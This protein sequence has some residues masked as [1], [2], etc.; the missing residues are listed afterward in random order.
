VFFRFS[1][2]P[3]SLFSRKVE[4]FW[5][6]TPGPGPPLCPS[7]TCTVAHPG[8]PVFSVSPRHYV[9]V[10]PGSLPTLLYSNP[11]ICRPNQIQILLCPNLFLLGSLVLI[12]PWFFFCP[13]PCGVL[14]DMITPAALF[15]N[16]FPRAKVVT[17]FP[18]VRSPAAVWRR[19]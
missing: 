11:A 9:F 1:N 4:L 12:F 15:L 18:P 7:Q 14:V 10:L 13:H 16:L 17:P 19:F 8:C 2:P 3:V 6:P 5:P